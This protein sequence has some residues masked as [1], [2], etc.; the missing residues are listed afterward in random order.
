M[1]RDYQ[2]PLKPQACP[3][4]LETTAAHS[5]ASIRAT[6]LY[7]ICIVVL[8]TCVALLLIVLARAARLLDRS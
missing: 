5:H 4:G 8:P 1:Q 3:P 2:R 7:I 6:L